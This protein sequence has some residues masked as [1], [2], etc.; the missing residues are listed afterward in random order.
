MED[1]SKIVVEVL[2]HR[3]QGGGIW[4]TDEDW[5]KLVE[6]LR[7]GGVTVNIPDH[8]AAPIR[9]GEEYD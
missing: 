1:N 7:A 9:G 5:H 3:V 6:A 8:G 4:M 2:V